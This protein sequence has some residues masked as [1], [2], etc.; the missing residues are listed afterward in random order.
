MTAASPDEYLTPYEHTRRALHRSIDIICAAWPQALDD[1]NSRGYP[2]GVDYNVRP[3]G[4]G[5]IVVEDE[6][7][8]PDRV[9]ATSVEMAALNESKAVA[10]L[11]ELG[12]IVNNL[13]GTILGEH[14]SPGVA[15]LTEYMHWCVGE[16]RFGETQIRQTIRLSN[17]ACLL[18]PPPPKNGVPR[19]AGR[20]FDAEQCLYCQ[21]PAYPGD[22]RAIKLPDGT[23]E[24]Y[25]HKS[26]CFHAIWA[27]RQ[28]QRSA[29]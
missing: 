3:T 27:A 17:V 6:N 26:P 24:G 13:R 12:D 29:S 28:R 8:E 11:A 14:R 25:A 2:T 7:G 22:R 16:E 23:V 5:S 19:G 20:P 1:A 21:T 15:P 18:W 9:P 10:W 4:G